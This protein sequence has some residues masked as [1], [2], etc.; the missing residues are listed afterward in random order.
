MSVNSGTPFHLSEIAKEAFRSGDLTRRFIDH[1]CRYGNC[2]YDRG[3]SSRDVV[4]LVKPKFLQEVVLKVRSD[5]FE[6]F[7]DGIQSTGRENYLT[8]NFEASRKA[9]LKSFWVKPRCV[10]SN[11]IDD[12][13]MFLA[14]DHQRKQI[15]G[16]NLMAMLE[17]ERK[18]K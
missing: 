17:A 13:L 10:M 15:T 3:R 18:S 4:W 16:E 6:L 2:D 14:S 9:E 5:G 7:I 1:M 12:A 8:I 11:V